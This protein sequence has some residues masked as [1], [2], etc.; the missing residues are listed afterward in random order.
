ML[1]RIISRLSQLVYHCYLPESADIGDGFDVG[2][3]GIGVIVHARAK[4]GRNVF[5]GPGAVIGGRSQEIGVPVVEDDVYIAAGAKVLGNIRIGSGSVV[6]ANAVVIKSVPA[7][8]AVAGVPSRIIKSE[9]DVR[10]LT[11]WPNDR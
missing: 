11:G 9:I 8:S 5:I 4:I 10:A 3:H 7:R 6:G 2:Y 1:P